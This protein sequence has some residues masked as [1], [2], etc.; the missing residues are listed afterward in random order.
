MSENLIRHMI[1]FLGTFVGVL[2]WLSGYVSGIRGWWWTIIGVVVIYMA[3]YNLI[4]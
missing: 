1:A 3:L 4:K 2:A